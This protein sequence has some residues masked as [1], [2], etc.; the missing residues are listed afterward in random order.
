[1]EFAR[2]EHIYGVDDCE[3]DGSE[4]DSG[5]VIEIEVIGLEVLVEHIA[6]RVAGLVGLVVAPVDD[7]RHQRCH[8]RD[9]AHGGLVVLFIRVQLVADIAVYYRAVHLPRPDQLHH[10]AAYRRP[11]LLPV[12]AWPPISHVQK[13]YFLVFLNICRLTLCGFLILI[14]IL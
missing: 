9:Q 8:L 5:G 6:N 14:L 11:P 2:D 3:E 13:R 10:A 1:V 4:C 7:D 12:D